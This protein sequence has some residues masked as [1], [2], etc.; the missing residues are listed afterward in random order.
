M[1]LLSV[2]LGEENVTVTD[3]AGVPSPTLESKDR[4]HFSSKGSLETTYLEALI[5]TSR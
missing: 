4:Q 1:A 3:L 5:N 2:S